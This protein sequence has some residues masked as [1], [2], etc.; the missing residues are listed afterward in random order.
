M[1]RATMRIKEARKK[2]KGRFNWTHQLR[3]QKIK[4][5]D[6]VL[7]YDNSLDNQHRSTRKFTKRWF[8]PYMVLAEL[9]G[10]R[11]TTLV[12]EKWIKAFKRR[13]EAEPDLTMGIEGDN[14][15]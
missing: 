6:W 10:T 3:P 8:G 15:D 5:G 4:E 9:D 13:N 7:V 2:N 14:S 11:M 12:A 1:E